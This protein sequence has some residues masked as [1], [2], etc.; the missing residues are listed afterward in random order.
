MR[1]LPF[2]TSLCTLLLLAAASARAI[3]VGVYWFV[4]DVKEPDSL[5]VCSLQVANS[6]ELANELNKK[7][8]PRCH[9]WSIES[10][11]NEFFPVGS[12]LH[13]E[14]LN[15]RFR[16]TFN[17]QIKGTPVSDFVSQIRGTAAPAATQPQS[18]KQQPPAPNPLQPAPPPPPPP[19][20]G[21]ETPPLDF[22]SGR[23][24]DEIA[25]VEQ[26]LGPAL[27][28]P[29][30]VAECGRNTMPYPAPS[31]GDILN[32]ALSLRNDANACMPNSGLPFQDE[33][34]FNK[35]TTRADGLI[36]SVNNFN[37]FVPSKSDISN[38]LTAIGS[39]IATLEVC[40]NRAPPDS[41]SRIK[42][43]DDE[44]AKRVLEIN[45]AMSQ[46][47]TLIN[48]LYSISESPKPF[49]L[50][51]QQ[52]NSS[53]AGQFSITE[54]PS[55]VSYTVTPAKPPSTSAP[56]DQAPIG[57]PPV[58]T[59]S[60]GV[61]NPFRSSSNYPS[62]LPIPVSFRPFASPLS[63]YPAAQTAVPAGAAKKPGNA[64]PSSDQQSANKGTVL[65]PSENFNVHRFYDGNIIAGFL[66]S[67]LRN[68]QYGITNNGQATSSTNVTY[69]AVVG[70]VTRPQYHAFVGID[71]YPWSRDVFPGA[72]RNAPF[73]RSSYLPGLLVGYGV[74][75]LNNYVLGA[76]WETHSGLNI[77]SGVHIGQ[78]SVLTPGIVPGV[79]QLPSS[80]TSAPTT[81]VT[82]YGWYGTI[83]FD[84]STMKAA[85]SQ[86]FGGSSTSAK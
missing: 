43:A 62:V 7:K 38:E 49:D 8:H 15:G 22:L 53:F 12:V 17:V 35:L 20:C 70:P 52:Y 32:F 39:D 13:V 21:P 58:T 41:W 48:Q 9:A 71:L 47:F 63:T 86:L 42:D 40:F 34:S 59:P 80:A 6:G 55:P 79:T 46:A 64:D 57:T 81:N 69:V 1:A 36:Q 84:L 78:E 11:R 66:V 3:P 72:Q 37:A 45:N 67:S 33:S 31:A 23:I 24:D 18:T 14:V 26:Y 44:V 76:D 75:A 5:S 51:L 54:V 68:R 56:G 28:A 4:Y 61:G 60:S 30:P 19:S 73:K 29:V 77:S 85:L 2:T 74:D 82:R 27:L 50:P 10:S 65:D 16:S 25:Q 83:G